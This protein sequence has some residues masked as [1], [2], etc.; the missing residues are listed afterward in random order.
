MKPT[1]TILLFAFLAA[2]SQNGS[3]LRAADESATKVDEN[4]VA[5]NEGLHCK[6][7]RKTGSRLNT[8]TCITKEQREKERR[9]S[10]ELIRNANANPATIPGNRG[11]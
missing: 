4:A 3:N 1:I 10:Q 9:D 8:R 5:Q 7:S 2:C 11:K 6:T